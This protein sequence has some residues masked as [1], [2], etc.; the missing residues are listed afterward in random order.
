M[1]LRRKTQI[2]L[3]ITLLILLLM[4]DLTFTNFLR[5]SAEQADIEGT[6]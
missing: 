5:R 6:T 3:G 2:S 1:T 4:L